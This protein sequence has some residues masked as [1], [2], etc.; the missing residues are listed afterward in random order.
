MAPRARS[1][2]FRASVAAGSGRSRI[3]DI[4]LIPHRRASCDTSLPTPELPPFWITHGLV[5]VCGSL[6]GRKSFNILHAVSGLTLTLAA[7]IA[8]RPDL[9][10]LMTLPES[11][12]RCVRH[13][14]SPTERGITHCPL[15]QLPPSG[16]AAAP[17]TAMTSKTPSLPGIAAGRAVP[18]EVLKRGFVA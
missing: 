17:P 5:L 4:L 14:P 16:F 8:L 7:S 2:L 9:L 6:G 1:S 10:I 15:S 11:T 13:V 18:R 3:M 12:C